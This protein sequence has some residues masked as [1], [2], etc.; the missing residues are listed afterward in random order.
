[1]S[2]KALIDVV[3]IGNIVREYIVRA[4]HRIG[5]VLGSPA[6]YTSLALVK[7]GMH[8]GI[9]SYCDAEFRQVVEEQLVSVDLEGC[10]TDTVT[11]ENH[12]IYLKKQRNRV[13]Y[14]KKAPVIF[15]EVIPEAYLNAPAYFI[16]PMDYE[17]SL[18]LMTSLAGEG[19]RL[20][21]DIGGFGGTTS[22]NHFTANTKRGRYMLERICDAA[23]F[24]KA[25]SDDIRYFFPDDKEERAAKKL[26]EM[27]ARGVLITM[28]EYGALCAL[29]DGQVC[30][31]D[32]FE[33]G[34][35]KIYPTGCGD[36]LTA[37]FIAGTERGYEV[38]KALEYGSAAAA[39]SLLRDGWCQESRMPT[40]GEIEALLAEKR[41]V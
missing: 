20:Y 7:Q 34:T 21:I 40:M 37:G 38:Q 39:L 27:G 33:P 3:L 10:L 2:K 31:T 32:A 13:E 15:R 12:L 30:Y 5:P 19:R 4:N 25:S 35:K 9:V 18:D 41:K 28:G 23:T 8:P 24:V 29:K 11:T 36:I 14:F 17:V 1:M 16:C 6:A 22:Y 26:I